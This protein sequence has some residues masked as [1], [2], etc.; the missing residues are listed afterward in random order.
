MCN[1]ESAIRVAVKDWN[2]MYKTW[3]VI[4][5][6]II[7]NMI[8]IGVR[9]G[10]IVSFYINHP[11]YDWEIPHKNPVSVRTFHTRK[12]TQMQNK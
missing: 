8:N 6:E 3:V 1:L 10:M 7:N 4:Q 11:N 9:N 2:L 5:K 12:R